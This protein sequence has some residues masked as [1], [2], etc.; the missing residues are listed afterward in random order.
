MKFK[1]KL[2]LGLAP[3]V[4][5]YCVLAYIFMWPPVVWNYWSF[6]R[7]TS[8]ENKC[9]NNLRIMDGAISEWALENGKHNGDPVTLADITPYIKQIKSN[10]QIPPICPMGG[11]YTITV[12]GAQPTCSFGGA[13]IRRGWFFYEVEPPHRMP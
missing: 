12:V 1:W 5:T 3:V 9:L 8:S 2:L 11:T 13:K 7:Q 6:H 10:A 4:L